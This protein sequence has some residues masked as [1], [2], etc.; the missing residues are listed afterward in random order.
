MSDTQITQLLQASS[1][2]D[3]QAINQLLTLVY[4]QLKVVAR[5]RLGPMHHG[6]TL[7]TTAL[8]NEAY[9]KMLGSGT[10]GYND[11]KHFFAVAA[12]AMRQIVIDNARKKLSQKRKGERSD[13]EIEQLGGGESQ[14]DTLLAIDAA[15]EEL[16]ETMPEEASVFECRY[17]VG[18]STNETAEA[19]DMPVR[20]VERRWSAARKALADRL[21][22][23]A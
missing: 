3:D 13:Q 20:T 16:K 23:K 10:D 5:G 8:V 12:T 21:E 18:F 4:G 11:R 22:R 19:L 14:P 15:L 2:G 17:F 6:Q 7:N 9:L 1:K